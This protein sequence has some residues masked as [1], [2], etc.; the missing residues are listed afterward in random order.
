MRRASIKVSPR[1]IFKFAQKRQNT[2]RKRIVAK[3]IS[4]TR[5]NN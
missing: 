4:I 5:A 3:T 1:K 2:V